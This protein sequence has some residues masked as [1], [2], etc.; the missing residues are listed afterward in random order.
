[1][2]TSVLTGHVTAD[3]KVE[4][5]A[6]VV[7]LEALGAPHSLLLVCQGLRRDAAFVMPAFKAKAGL[8]WTV[9]TSVLQ[10]F[11]NA[12]RLSFSGQPEEA[13]ITQLVEWR[14]PHT[15]SILTCQGVTN[16]SALAGC[17]SLHTLDR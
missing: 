8:S 12:K 6:L 16:V 5:L 10:K 17:A 15:L 11:P 14:D 2:D 1:M 7:S 13:L 9:I 3:Q 4:V